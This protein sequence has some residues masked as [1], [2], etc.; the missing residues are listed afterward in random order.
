M[1]AMIQVRAVAR[2][3]SITTNRLVLLFFLCVA[4][5]AIAPAQDPLA[6][7]NLPAIDMTCTHYP[8]SV[9]VTNSLYEVYQ[10][11]G[12]K[13]CTTWNQTVY[14]TQNEI[15]DFQVHFHDTGSGT[16]G[17]QV[18][19]SSFVGPN[20]SNSFTIEAP[21]ATHRDIVV[22]RE[23]YINVTTTSA[24]SNASTPTYL[25]I[26]QNKSGATTGLIPDILIPVIDPYYHQTTN[27]FPF[28]IAGGNNQ[29]VFVDVHIP[30]TA[31]S[32]Y[33]KGTV[34][35]ESGCPG[36]CTAITTIPIII[37]VWQWPHAGFMPS[38]ATLHGYHLI[39]DNACA[40]F[41]G[42]TG[43]DSACSAWPGSGGS[44]NTAWYSM[45]RD[46]TT[47]YLDHRLQAPAQ[48]PM[49]L[50]SPGTAFDT[51]YGPLMNGTGNTILPAAKINS[52][53]WSDDGGTYQDWATHFSANG[54]TPTLFVYGPDEP[55]S[56]A[57][58]QA[59]HS[60]AVTL[61][62]L[63][64]SVP[65]LITT[66]FRR[67]PSAANQTAICGSATCV[68]NSIDWLTTNVID[69]ATEI[70][71]IVTYRAFMAGSSNIGTPPVRRWWSYSACDSTQCGGQSGGGGVYLEN[72]S[73]ALD[74]TSI[75]HRVQTW[76][77][78][79]AGQT[80]DLYFL[81][82]ACWAPNTS[83]GNG[84]NPW[85]GVRYG[86][87]NG[88]GTLVYPGRSVGNPTGFND[89]GVTTPIF[90]PSL[91]LKHLRD[92]MQDYEIMSILNDNGK[93]AVV[94]TAINSF[95]VT[96][97]GNGTGPVLNWSFNNTQAPVAGVFTSDL[98]DARITLGTALHQL[99]YSTV[100]MPPPTL[101]GTVQ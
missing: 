74:T 94:T 51:Y 78:L 57:Q 44:Y 80:G 62:G 85:A 30:P 25:N 12:I 50:S 15:V 9:W 4:L 64:P 61:H 3:L 33:Y 71:N 43:F 7:S 72:P 65:Q 53:A 89:V 32:G 17:F 42:G 83:C 96:T 79:Y 81:D 67:I 97:T 19:I 52:V 40:G 90:L 20:P 29:S 38:T 59:I 86:G 18:Q 45:K 39:L 87:T 13:D 31:P 11:T 82:V 6:P 10:N 41:Y 47:L 69:M 95:M 66:S 73:N 98:P 99:S 23:A 2:G 54:W 28:N 34:T 76:F 88:D 16:N 55:S 58:W 24:I 92:G 60:N 26:M 68:T 101:S 22:Y 5:P 21:D 75:A 1:K 35:V 84:G 63:T 48:V 56:Q 70:T 93:N 27:A 100:L 36:S 77:D 14:G 8:S 46:F 49:S 91:R 37:A